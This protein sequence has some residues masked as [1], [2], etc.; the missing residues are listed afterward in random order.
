MEIRIALEWVIAVVLVSLRLTPIML[1]SPLFSLAKIP[2][3]FRV[4]FTLAL[5]VALIINLNISS[6]I[7][8]GDTA[9]LMSAVVYELMLGGMLAF[10]ISTAFAAFQLGGRILDIQM[11][12]GIAE[13][14]DPLS[15]NQDPLLGTLLNLL[16]LTLFF[17][18]DGH[19]LLMRGIAFS[20]EK[21][22]IGGAV[23]AWNPQILGA[24]FGLIFI[25]GMVIVAPV[26]I[27]LLLVDIGLAVV[28]R[29]MP[30]VNIFILSIPIKIFLGLMMLAVSLD[31][32]QP[33]FAKIFT[34]VFQFWEAVIQ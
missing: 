11:G 12:F 5:S 8:P 23:T 16:A 30:Q 9:A 13:L 31:F 7:S 26:I 19:H 3:K 20:L 4:L 33:V 2:V 28:S 10:G 29:A 17:I 32:M 6:S 27:L 24:Q 15:G 22:P 34:A 14:V 21:L 18:A 25:Y 1:F